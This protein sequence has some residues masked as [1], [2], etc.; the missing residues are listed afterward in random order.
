MKSRFYFF[1]REWKMENGKWTSIFHF[2]L[3][4]G[5]EKWEIDGHFPLFIFQLA[6]N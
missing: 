5:N 2:P 1:S 4:I 3:S 6:Y